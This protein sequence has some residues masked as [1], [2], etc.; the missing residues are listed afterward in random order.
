[1]ELGYADFVLLCRVE[2]PADWADW[3]EL[4]HDGVYIKEP[5]SGITFAERAV[6]SRHP[7]GDLSKPALKFPCALAEFQR[8][9]EDQ[10]IYGAV[11]AFDMAD[12][13]RSKLETDYQLKQRIR[14][15]S[16]ISE[17]RASAATRVQRTLL[18]IIT[19]LLDQA[20]IDPLDR[21]AASKIAD[22]T[23][24]LGCKVD[25]DTVRKYLRMLPDAGG[26]GAK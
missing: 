22:V 1:M 2:N 24:Y 9:L 21:S 8:F 26:S 17:P 10:D 20:H 6:L 4:R 15:A 5:C 13:V 16:G 19:A 3:L 12:W 11:D 7:S 23:E 18:S 25:A 14:S